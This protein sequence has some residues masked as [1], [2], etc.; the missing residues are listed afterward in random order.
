MLSA[1]V[2]PTRDIRALIEQLQDTSR[3]ARSRQ[4]V[5]EEERD[6]LSRQIDK[7][8]AEMGE[9]ITL[10][11][12]TEQITAERDRLLE[13]ST[14]Y[15]EM[16]A[17]LKHR[18]EIAERQVVDVKRV[19]EEFSKQ[20]VITQKQTEDLIRQRD[21][22]TKES[23]ESKGRAQDLKK[24]LADAERD[25]AEL[26]SKTVNATKNGGESQKQ[27]GAL[28][29]AR[30][31]AAAQVSE[32]KG[33]IAALEDQ[34]AELEDERAAAERQPKQNEHIA[35]ER[36]REIAEF[37][38]R[39]DSL[40]AAHES[41][42]G[43]ARKQHEAAMKERDVARQRALELEVQLEK[44]T[45]D[46]SSMKSGITASVAV[47][48]E[49]EKRELEMAEKLQTFEK[50]EEVLRAQLAEAERLADLATRDRDTA[51]Q[52]LDDAR[53]SLI[54][55][56]K[57]IETIT[58]DR[59]ANRENVQLD[60]QRSE[61]L[62]LRK[63]LEAAQPKLA[64]YSKLADRF[65][66]QRLET[67]EL[68]AQLENAQRDIK[69]MGAS[70][71]EARLMLKDFERRAA[72][73]VQPVGA[74]PSPSLV[75]VAPTEIVAK[76]SGRAE[77]IANRTTVGEM[78]KTFQS[79]TRRPGDSGLLSD[80]SALAQR[81]A[82][83]TRIDGEQ[84]LHRVSSCF[85]SLIHELYCMPEQVSPAI[86]R[87]VN[88]SVEFLANL[89]KHDNLDQSVSLDT[90]R[91]YAVDDDEDVCET[92]ASSVR[93]VGF[94]IK[95]TTMPGEAVSDLAG[96]RFD[97][98]IL[99]VQLPELDGFELCTHIRNMALHPETPII[100][101]TGNASMENRVQSSLRG[102]NDFLAKPFNFLELGLKVLSLVLR[103][104]LKML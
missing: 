72:V 51:T 95:T 71:A 45:H 30:D 102:G 38:A 54:A 82:E 83:Q 26:R 42:L 27:I 36:E 47:D 80:L 5:A 56:N 8:Q 43:V 13:Q 104:Q 16:L 88:Q 91:V 69:G 53:Y 103:S 9:A 34:V 64:E 46:I 62:R 98:I 10:S 67:I 76:S 94:S 61:T 93:A 100:F 60:E 11:K 6:E 23:T 73:P 68:A 32:M 84:V 96:H 59:D 58:A 90:V 2:D 20:R 70:L 21:A 97:L 41:E 39:L 86:L 85:A 14:K 33:R 35:A 29:Q 101:L 3:E 17:E 15:G 57:Q 28:K 79:Y 52:S 66:R 63:E 19:N 49:R 40:R 22:L 78:R 75:Q 25:L 92:V 99:D 48:A 81:L 4:K 7:I 74:P 37:T 1:E 65:E 31:A 50:N 55:A 89:L 44:L 77:N 12:Q 18:S 24:R 87:T